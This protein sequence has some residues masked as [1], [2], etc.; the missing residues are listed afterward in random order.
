[1]KKFKKII[2]GLIL[3]II[4]IILALNSLEI[5]NID[6]FFEGWWTLFIIIPSFFGLISDS[7]KTGSIIGITIGVLLLL[8]SNDII[9]FDIIWKLIVPIIL[10]GIGLSFIFKNSI[11]NKLNKKIDSLNKNNDTNSFNATFSS[12]NLDFSDEEFKGCTLDAVFGGIKLDIRNAN[13][14]CDIVINTTSIF[15]GID[16]LLPEGYNIS[17]MLYMKSVLNYLAVYQMKI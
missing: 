8:S 2:W 9:D 12:Q 7:D 10:I 1:M 4:G 13:I 3:I 17:N 15:G 6:I 11:N 16:I 5:T 14:N